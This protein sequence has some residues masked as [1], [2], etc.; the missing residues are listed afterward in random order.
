MNTLQ[1][2]PNV[3][4]LRCPNEYD[5][6][7]RQWDWNYQCA[8]C[9]SSLDF[10]QC[11][12]C[13]GEGTTQPGELHEYDPLWY[14]EDDIETCHLCDGQASFPYCCSSYLWC[15]THPLPGRI[16]IPP[17]TPEWFAMGLR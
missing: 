11:S 6:E 7:A 13:G 1:A 12:E 17:S 3:I 4:G 2:P 8:R 15:L 9:G 5:R 14:D 16:E 10:E